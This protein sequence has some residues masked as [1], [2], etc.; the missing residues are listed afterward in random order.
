MAAEAQAAAATRWDVVI[1]NGAS[2]ETDDELYYDLGKKELIEYENIK[3]DQRI[4]TQ[5]QDE[6]EYDLYFTSSRKSD[7]L[8][9]EDASVVA[10][11]EEVYKAAEAEAEAKEQQRQQAIALGYN[12]QS[13]DGGGGAIAASVPPGGGGSAAAALAAQ[14]DL[15]TRLAA[16]FEGEGVDQQLLE[17]LLGEQDKALEQSRGE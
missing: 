2:R 14:L 9:I 7:P 13:P 1:V 11:A 5:G 3:E 10:A 4:L 6:R 8:E 16:V 17:A 15:E 12:I